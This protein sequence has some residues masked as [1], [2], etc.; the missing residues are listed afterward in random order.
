MKKSQRAKQGMAML[1]VI[2]LTFP[3]ML[4]V[5]MLGSMAASFA[6]RARSTVQIEQ[7]FF[8]AEGGIE[9]GV[10]YIAD[11]NPVPA[12]L[13]ESLGA[14][15]FNVV[16]LVENPA[17][18]SSAVGGILR[19][20]PNNSPDASFFAMLPDGSY[21]TR[22]DLLDGFDGYDG[23]ARRVHFR[24]MGGGTQAGVS[25]DGAAYTIQN[26]VIYDIN[27]PAMTVRIYNDHPQKAMGHWR[28][29]INAANAVFT[30]G[31]L[32]GMSSR[33]TRYQVFSEGTVNGRSRR[34]TIQGLHAISWARY[35]LWYNDE[36]L[37]LWMVGGEKFQGPV[38]ANVEMRFHSWN[39]ATLGQTR[40][41]DRTTTA[42]A[43]YSRQTDAVQ[44][45]FDRGISLGVDAQD[46]TSINFTELRD[47]ASLVLQGTTQISLAGTNMVVTNSRKGWNNRSMPVPNDGLIYV[48]TVTTGDNASRPGDLKLSAVAGLNGRLTLVSDRDIQIV[49]HIRYASNPINFPMSDDALGLI[50]KRHVMVQTTA[51]NNL[52]IFAHIIATEGGFGVVNYDSSSAGARGMLNVYG[53]I[54]NR[55]RQAVGTTGGTGYIKNYVYDSRFQTEPPPGYPVVP[56]AYQWTDWSDR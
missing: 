49:N 5:A 48:Q 36:A 33:Y 44:P 16:I 6:L 24:P 23:P 3:A 11:G 29:E 43:S 8:I 25:V 17:G 47:D 53:G 12:T 41:Y 19:I 22:Q 45:V 31:S 2:C 4:A 46:T 34:V 21:I 28:L 40:F 27:S 37:Q 38:H 18:G 13:N 55:T 7:A 50:A 26:N 20:N 14:G 54:V 51:P 56:N 32:P 15:A 52:D 42:A 1:L 30:D 10:Q 39:V 9:R 35:A